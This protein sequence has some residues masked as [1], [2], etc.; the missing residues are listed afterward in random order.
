M[1]GFAAFFE[2]DRQ[3]DRETLD[4][5]DRD[6]VH[7]GPD[8]SGRHTAP[9][10]ALVFRRL[11]IMDPETRS[12]QPMWDASRRYIIVFNG[13]IYNFKDLRQRLLEDGV[14][15]RTQGDTE[16]VIEGFVRWGESIVELLE[17]MF[18]FTI[19]DT[20][21]NKV[22][23]ARD[24]FG[25]KPLYMLRCSR[26][27]AFAS[28]TKPLRRLLG[29][30]EVDEAALAELLMFRFAAGRFSN[31]KGIE[32]LPGGSCVSYYID[33]GQ[34]SERQYCDVLN[35]IDPDPRIDRSAAFAMSED[36]VSQ[37]IEAHM[38]S[39]VGYAIQLSGGVDSSLVLALAAEK[40][41]QK[42][43]SYSVRLPDPKLDEEEFRKPVI[44]RYGT[45][46]SEVDLGPVA[47][48]DA[49]P[50]AIAHME[51]PTPH[52]GCVMLMLLCER[53]REKH[54]VVLTGEGA[55]EFFGGYHRY[56]I[57][58]TLRLHGRIAKRV[59][60]LLWPFLKRYSYLRRFEKYPPEIAAS[61]YLDFRFLHTLFPGLVPKPG[62]REEAAGRFRDFRDRML[63]V[64]QS[65][66]LQSLLMRQD[67]MA[68]AASVE[69]RVPF[70]HMPVA[71]ALNRLPRDIRLPG[72]ETKPL[73]KEI[74]RR[75]LPL[76]VVD[77]RKVGLN[78]PLD[79][80][81]RNDKGL[82]RYLGYLTASDCRLAEFTDRK[83]LIRLVDDFRQSSQRSN[84]PPLAHLVNLEL[85]LR[86]AA[87]V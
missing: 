17:G 31:F 15:L 14:S 34:Y 40:S 78:L 38:Q 64:D 69:A 81:L 85:W 2:S 19:V 75:Y 32:L 76:D 84:Q 52:Y 8:G 26:G 25:I 4:A 67:K 70:T 3:F 87:V 80:W 28:E 30:S 35:T 60:V 65:S 22:F 62:V 44:A 71:K 12:D 47:F 16:V 24:P 53:I 20:R 43:D 33:S 42:L 10:M 9:G 54:K 29:R 49:L 63:A 86:S 48:A 83:S 21:D 68:M 7:R 58:Q 41:G 73:L 59:P 36:V 55:D 72:G 23:A 77:R 5:V 11:A 74:A 51:G 46:H 57:W 82:G 1:C 56:N 6:L 79:D 13:E 18:A 61:V 39:D 37:S 45:N 66:Y 50:R 27:L